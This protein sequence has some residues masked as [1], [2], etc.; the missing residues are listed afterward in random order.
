MTQRWRTVLSAAVLAIAGAAAPAAEPPAPAP[1]PADADDP[2]VIDLSPAVQANVR[3][4]TGQEQAAGA[5]HSLEAAS[6]LTA[7]LPLARQVFL[8]KPGGKEG[9]SP[10]QSR[11]IIQPDPGVPGFEPAPTRVV[12]DERNLVVGWDGPN[13]TI[14]AQVGIAPPD[15]N[16]A[17]GPTQVMVAT[18]D[19]VQVYDKATG[20][21]QLFP[22]PTLDSFFTPVRPA[23]TFTTDPKL[24]YDPGSSRW[25]LI[26]LIVRTTDLY[27]WYGIAV[28]D[29]NN[30]LGNWQLYRSDSTVEGSV[31]TTLFSDY[32]GLGVNQDA[33]YISANMF[34]RTGSG[35]FA[36]VKVRIYPKT[37]LVTFNPT[38]VFTDISDFRN[39][40]NSVSDNIQPAVHFGASSTVFMVNSQ[41]PTRLNVF[42]ITNPLGAVAVTIRSATVG[43]FS[44]PADAQQPGSG[45]PLLDSI[46]TRVYNSVW[47]S[48]SL[49][50]AH[51]TGSGGWPAVRWYQLTTA[52][53]P[54]GFGATQSGTIASSGRALWFPAVAANGAG[55]AVI[56]YCRSGPTD[57]A[58]MAYSFRRATDTAGTMT[59]PAVVKAGLAGYIGEATSTVRWGDYT[60]A[61]ADPSDDQ[62]FWLFNQY[63]GGANQWNTWIQKITLPS[64]FAVSISSDSG[65]ATAITVSPNDS[66][67]QGSGST[68]FTRNYTAGTGVT[69]T[70]PAASN[71]RTFVRWL[72]NGSPAPGNP[73][74][75]TVNAAATAQAQYELRRGLSVGST[76]TSGVPVTV[77]PA[78]AAGQGSGVT[79]FARTYADGTSVTLT[80]PASAGTNVVFRNWTVA[81]GDR[82]QGQTSATIVLSADTAAVANFEIRRTVTVT[83][84][85]QGIA[86]GLFPP[87]VNGDGGGVTSFSRVYPVGTAVTFS[88]PLNPGSVTFRRWTLGGVAQPSHQRVVTA[89][90]GDADLSAEAVYVC[91]GDVD[92]VGGVGANDL[93]LLLTAFGST[94]GSPN[95]NP[96]A[97]IDQNGSVGANDLS[98][99]LSN[100]GCVSP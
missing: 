1:A 26:C 77:S 99:L 34:N 81:G 88:A 23:S 94:A 14:T 7:R 62:S 16:L 30:P 18:N 63:A 84:R 5:L 67:G 20:Q 4:A 40:D 3:V 44:V 78:D 46:D 85:P 66:G 31:A 15:P 35:A 98:V 68:P 80:A 59:A 79:P 75:F 27:S 58:G 55:A 100:W 86:L 17:V 65:A 91:S 33:L 69:L 21:A 41:A 83:S 56:G 42:A 36:Y 93:S 92:G 87:D 57:F 96:D 95:Y 71:G 70:A 61:V 45:V 39:A 9:L 47:R 11:W 10:I 43:A 38:L 50:L 73:V 97:D 72:I 54:T 29:D 82:P 28:S 52:N 89:T 32:P 24:L 53:W 13:E 25:F 6:V 12:R 76:G 48:G 49:W 90:V 37:Q 74:T 64:V 60:G 2:R 19:V 22:A 51:N 8:L